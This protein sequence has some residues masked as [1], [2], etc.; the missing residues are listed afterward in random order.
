[1]SDKKFRISISIDSAKEAADKVGKIFTEG[2]PASARKALGEISASFS[3]LPKTINRQLSPVAKTADQIEKSA[4][5]AG[6]KLRS[7]KGVLEQLGAVKVSKL[8]NDQLQGVFSSVLGKEASNLGKTLDSAG[9]KTKNYNSLLKQQEADLKKVNKLKKKEELQIEA[10][11]KTLIKSIKAR[12]KEEEAEVRELRRRD[13]TSKILSSVFSTDDT[14]D[15]KK[16]SSTNL[17]GVAQQRGASGRDFSS[18]ASIAGDEDSRGIVAAYA[19]LAANI[20]ALT[21]AFQQ[22][23]E[24]AKFDQLKKGLE[25][26]GAS[27]GQTFSVMARGLQEITGYAVNT[28]D[29]MRSVA[30][31]TSAGLGQKDIEDLG[32][33]AKG[34]S[35]ALGRDL[36]DSM[37]RL[38][39][40]AIKLEPEILDELGIMVRLDDAVATYANQLGK[41]KSSLT[42]YE[43]RQ[44]FLNEVITQGER[45]FGD[46]AGSVDVSPYDKLLATLQNLNKDGFRAL[47][48][49]LSPVASLL[50]DNPLLLAV[51]F[52][53]LAN[54]IAKK[55]LPNLNTFTDKQSAATNIL[56]EQALAMKD[57][58]DKA[59]FNSDKARVGLREE[60][61]LSGTRALFKS[62]RD[63]E[64]ISEE[65]I[66]TYKVLRLS[67]R[68]DQDLNLQH[69]ATI[70]KVLVSKT[71]LNAKTN[72][73]LEMYDDLSSSLTRVI[74]KEKERI[75][76]NKEYRERVNKIT[77]KGDNVTD[78]ENF[79]SSA[80]SG[81]KV[82]GSLQA[83]PQLYKDV[84]ANS[85]KFYAAEKANII[86]QQQALGTYGTTLGKIRMSAA[87]A[88]TRVQGLGAAAM[89][90]AQGV[91]SAFT[92][93]IPIVGG[94][95]T[96]FAIGK[97][98]WDYITAN[99]KLAKAKKDLSDIIE[100]L[101]SKW[102]S[103]N[104]IQ[105]RSSLTANEF[106]QKYI[107]ISNVINETIQG[108]DKLA[109]AH[110][111]VSKAKAKETQAIYDYAKANNT[112]LLVASKAVQ[113]INFNDTL[114][115]GANSKQVRK[116]GKE[117]T[118]DAPL[119]L[120]EALERATIAKGGFDRS[121]SKVQTL[122]R[123]SAIMKE[124]NRDFKE[125][126]KILP[127]LEQSFKEVDSQIRSFVTAS[128]VT[129]K[130]D[131][132]TN[133]FES[134]LNV[135]ENLE[136]SSLDDKI[137]IIT[138]YTA[139]ASDEMKNLLNL[140]PNELGTLAH[141]KELQETLEKL[142][143][144]GAVWLQAFIKGSLATAF[145]D[146]T[147]LPDSIEATTKALQDT[148]AEIITIKGEIAK[149]ET[150]N[151]EDQAFNLVRAKKDILETNLGI[152]KRE[153]DLNGRN[154]YYLRQVKAEE[155]TI[156]NAIN[157][158]L[159]LR[160]EMI[161]LQTVAYDTALKAETE[162]AK[163]RKTEASSS[164]T[165]LNLQHQ[166]LDTAAQ[167]AAARISGDTSFTFANDFLAKAAT[168]ESERLEINEQLATATEAQKSRNESIFKLEQDLY[169]TQSKKYGANAQYEKALQAQLNILYKQRGAEREQ[170][171]LLKAKAE[172]A[173]ELLIPK[174]EELRVLT[175]QAELMESLAATENNRIDAYR[176]L[177]QAQLRLS[178]AK[179]SGLA[180]LTPE[181]EIKARRDELRDRVEQL[182]NSRD[183]EH[184]TIKLRSNAFAI[185][186][187]LRDKELSIVRARLFALSKEKNSN[188]SAGEIES[189]LGNI[190]NIDSAIISMT[191]NR[192]L[193]EKEI[194]EVKIQA[195]QAAL[196]ISIAEGNAGDI[197][198]ANRLKQA[199]E[200]ED[201]L[202]HGRG[203]FAQI[204]FVGQQYQQAFDDFRRT[205]GRVPTEE[206]NAR[207]KKSSMYQSMVTAQIEAQ[208]ALAPAVES[209][210][211][212][213]YDNIISGNQSV[214]ESFKQMAISI[215][216][217]LAKVYLRAVM[218]QAITA[219]IGGGFGTTSVS[220][221]ASSS[222]ALD[223]FAGTAFGNF[224]SPP[225]YAKGGIAGFA[226]QGIVDKPTYLAG[227]G[228]HNEAI[229][230][231]P[232]GRAIPVEMGGSSGQTNNI[233]VQV[234]VDGAGN[235]SS[236]V[237]G[238]NMDQM[239]DLIAQAIQKELLEQKRPGGILNKNGVS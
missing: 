100:Q 79:E 29:A 47:N 211:M 181:Q 113:Q 42:A 227:E 225:M 55:V 67:K 165:R 142:D 96:V 194:G 37:D 108:L 222:T 89:T 110:N 111:R 1:M 116:L 202:A 185:E 125:M 97:M 122:G 129:T 214:A 175:K 31:A 230:P 25:A 228:K 220:A 101:S 69:V 50:S 46:I 143:G 64:E 8:S 130:L 72:E 60:I 87:L 9:M 103:L 188:V 36:G 221:A 164:K 83:L 127:E 88:A 26:L 196:D 121:M 151:K 205:T 86:Q 98:V 109:L 99:E 236:N 17:R 10:S 233:N 190:E 102:E 94:L 192:L 141:I 216:A 170:I 39:R 146:L 35:I 232:N 131:G 93:L 171:Q 68:Q 149:L 184:L 162:L 133:S 20:F 106:S 189:V 92:K 11:S 226:N 136:K 224:G 51:P 135:V 71:R 219:A 32:K 16:A 168:I 4:K 81:S 217:D 63:E 140:S 7:F 218:V 144:T 159:K 30:L 201:T 15:G 176:E 160:S 12:E 208:S 3:E 65:L 115:S 179:T 28:R 53:I 212:S 199:K 134:L 13:R 66:E 223:G 24:A 150:F 104:A 204:P 207:L 198:L 40:G 41:A 200:L 138:R 82:F 169:E 124:A 44:A 152:K 235:A 61:N 119:E 126:N 114:F 172:L 153:I 14:K 209:A 167:T 23:S 155:S 147:S 123:A 6:V 2:L 166:I 186:N 206:E 237:T 210:F 213:F 76:L 187:K 178:N 74:Q 33:V 56:K 5:A 234:K 157:E 193:L 75:K 80:A 105:K 118:E 180:A 177:Y 19:T 95:M 38:A 45:K 77:L 27:S 158:G 107:V 18:L 62:L 70:N 239:G 22:L 154:I 173:A 183:A 84:L 161:I 49:V 139:E 90:F 215:I 120:I 174:K 163:L 85:N 229:V 78:L 91:S 128:K 195:A 21:T 156:Q 145:D 57:L 148:Q 59:A 52:S 197:F 203:L 54:I 34:A 132:M 231:L 117:L 48:T 112:S 58:E 182:K 238:D 43:R 137:A 73:E 191:N